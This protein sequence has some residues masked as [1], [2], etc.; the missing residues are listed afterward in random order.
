MTSVLN[1]DSNSL[2]NLVQ[3]TLYGQLF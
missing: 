2:Q 1:D 3:V